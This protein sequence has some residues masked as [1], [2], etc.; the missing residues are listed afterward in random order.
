MS[1]GK[2]F[3]IAILAALVAV[4]FSFDLGQYFTLEFLQSEKDNLARYY[5]REKFT[6]IAV[7]ML[8]YI[9][10]TALSLPGAVIMT[11]AGG[12]VF[13]LLEGTIIVSFASTIGAT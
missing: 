2:I 6:T 13:G 11:L 4:F 9:A 3:L 7:Y 8:V 5:E 10:V 12:A 1:K